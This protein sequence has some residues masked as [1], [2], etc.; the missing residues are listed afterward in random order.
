MLE[1]TDV[2]IIG[3]GPYGLSIAAH[4]AE[5][6][7]DFRIYGLPMAVWQRHMPAGMFLKSE[8]FASTL[9]DPKRTMTLRQYCSRYG[10]AY[11]PVGLP[12]SLD[13]FCRYGL[14]FQKAMVPDLDSRLVAHL[15]RKGLGFRL[16]LEDGAEIQARRVIMAVGISHFAHLPPELSELPAD[17]AHHTSVQQPAADYAGRKVVVIG[18]GS[19][20]V[21][22]AALLQQAGADVQLVT[23]RPKVWFNSPPQKLSGLRLAYA[24]ALKPRSGLGLGW[25]SRMASDLPDVFH[26]MPERFRAKVNRG[27]LGPSASWVSHQM[28]AG[29][30]TMKHRLAL[31]Q[32]ELRNGS[33][34]LTFAGDNG[35]LEH[36]RADHVIAGTGYKVDVDLL[37]F[38]DNSIRAD[39][40]RFGTSPVLNRNFESSVR[41]LFFVGPSAA[42]SFGPLLRFAWGANFAASRLTAHLRSAASKTTNPE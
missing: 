12:V 39:I 25:R 3:A 22:T 17:I 21:D 15:Y 2:V 31:R 37:G 40:A 27:H 20:A 29:K 24:R 11:Q 9:F 16:R 35:E 34:W 26:R 13:L 32:A 7:V 41:G 10:E 1:Q 4:L 19:S 28:V 8:G 14:A 18:G 42:S 36:V 5:R 30:L 38:L 23:R 6:G 33:A